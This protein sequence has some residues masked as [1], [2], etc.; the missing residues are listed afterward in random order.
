MRIYGLRIYSLRIYDLNNGGNLV[1]ILVYRGVT[2]CDLGTGYA[3]AY[4]VDSKTPWV[5]R[6]NLVKWVGYKARDPIEFKVGEESVSFNM[7]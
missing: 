3:L 2:V 4:K 1:R 5:Y 6:V 7:V